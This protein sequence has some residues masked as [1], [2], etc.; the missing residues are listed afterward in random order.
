MEHR[1]LKCDLVT[2]TYNISY[3]T[4]AKAV[5]SHPNL[6]KIGDS[7]YFRTPFKGKLGCELYRGFSF[8]ELEGEKITF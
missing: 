5:E 4:I 1:Q 3:E 6:I 2:N 8:Q 7:H